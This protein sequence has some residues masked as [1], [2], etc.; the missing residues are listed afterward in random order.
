MDAAFTAQHRGGAGPPLV[1][2]HGF[3]DTWRTWELVL[4]ELESHFDVFAP[5]LVGHAGG[6]PLPQDST[7]EDLFDALEHSLDEAGIDTAH[8]AGNSLGGYASLKLAE[9]GRA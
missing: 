9:R 7:D 8:V 4:P 2:I 3:T 6:P 1:L 5:T